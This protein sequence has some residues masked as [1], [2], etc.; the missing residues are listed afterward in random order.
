MNKRDLTKGSILTSLLIVA[1]PILINYFVLM[2]YNLTD[3]FWVGKISTDE[4]S[5]TMAVSAVGTGAFYPWIGYGLIMIGMMGVSINVSH[6]AGSN[7]E[8]ELNK[9]GTSGIVIMLFFSILYTLFGFFFADFY[10]GLFGIDNDIV[11]KESINYMR[12]LSL[13]GVVYYLSNYFVGVYNGVGRAVIPVII[14]G[15]GV[16]INMILDPILILVF[17][18]GVSGAAI[19]TGISQLFG[20]IVIVGLLFTKHKPCIINFKK[21]FSFE[22]MK[23][24][25]KTGFAPGMQ[26]IF[27]TIICMIIAMLVADFGVEAITTSRL[28]SQVEQFAWM[29][30]IGFQIA[31]AS[32]VGQNF[33]ANRMD[34]IEEGIKLSLKIL[35]VYGLIISLIFFFFA[36]FIVRIFIDDLVTVEYTVTYLKIYSFCQIFSVLE[37]AITGCFNGLNKTI[38][39][40]VISALFNIGR[41]V[42]AIVLITGFGLNGIWYAN[43]ISTIFKGLVMLFSFIYV[44]KRLKSNFNES[45]V[46]TLDAV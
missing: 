16:L 20:F 3:L 24:I 14:T 42:F 2:A 46:D 37:I 35:V 29:I 44:F 40:S 32:F 18:M 36:E 19:A 26:S 45:I 39:P 10:I 27:F 1:I 25:L 31:L 28:G 17:N 34:R 4:L 21:Y 7:E 33:G 12:I 11:V 30:A 8:K 5:G 38:Y 22:S 41:V 43:T 13:F 9:F 6:K 15:I 23:K